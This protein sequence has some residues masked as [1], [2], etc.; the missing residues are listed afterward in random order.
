MVGPTDELSPRV[1]ASVSKKIS[2]LAAARNTYRRRI[3]SAARPILSELEPNL[4]LIV[5]KKGIDKVKG[6][7]LTNE[8]RELFA[9]GKFIVYK[10]KKG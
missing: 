4:Y 7:A 10:G 5:A 1:A 6:E 3:Y 9:S 8:L 2:K